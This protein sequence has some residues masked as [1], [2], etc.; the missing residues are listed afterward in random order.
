MERRIFPLS[1]PLWTVSCCIWI[2]LGMGELIG[3]TM[4]KQTSLYLELGGPGGLGSLNIERTCS[5]RKSVQ[6]AYR[7]GLSSFPIDRNNG[8]VVVIPVG[9]HGIAGQAPHFMDV[10]VGQV[11]S[12][13]TKGKFHFLG[14][15]AIGYRHQKT[16]KPVFFRLS[17]TP[18]ISYLLTYQYQHWAGLTIGY[19]FLK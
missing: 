16:E 14:T 13:T 4:Q 12:F 15:S 7:I 9:I 6:F 5:Q 2:C 8:I 19:T 1:L 3:Q 17:Y 11:I 18:L 10:S